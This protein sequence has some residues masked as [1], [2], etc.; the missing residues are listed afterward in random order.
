[1][2]VPVFENSLASLMDFLV[3][4]DLQEVKTYVDK[5]RSD[6]PLLSQR[7]LA[8]KIVDEQSINNGLLGAVTGL[9]SLATLPVTI[10]LDIVK[11]W[12]IQDFTIRCIGHIYGYTPQNTDLK[13]AILLLMSNGSIEE[14]KQLVIVE[15]ANAVNQYTLSTVDTFKTSAIQLV[16]KEGPKYAAKAITKYGEKVVVNCGMKEISKY[17]AEVLCK[18]GCKKIAEKVLQ[19][20]LGVAVP[21]IG[22]V[23]GGSVDWVTT[24]A[25]GKLAIEYF[26]NSGPEFVKKTF[27][28]QMKR[29]VA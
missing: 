20:S 4:S 16:A 14:L 3:V 8:Q 13:T 28:L 29:S 19:K 11:G 7:E 10:P 9:G 27:N 12:K 6:N 24:Q 26:E 22:A 2:D 1:M 5:L 17:L 25:V 18:I 21:V 23:I 15:T